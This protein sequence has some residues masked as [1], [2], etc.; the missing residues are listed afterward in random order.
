MKKPRSQRSPITGKKVTASTEWLTEGRRFRVEYEDS[1]ARYCVRGDDG[2]TVLET[3]KGGFSHGVYDL[4]Y[5]SREFRRAFIALHDRV[6]LEKL[7]PNPHLF[8]LPRGWEM[9]PFWY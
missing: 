2:W 6:M 7:G 8:E 5:A 4:M 1:E 3:A 9:A